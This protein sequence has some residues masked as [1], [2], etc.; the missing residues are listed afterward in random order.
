ML[1]VAK[2]AYNVILPILIVVGIG[3]WFG[4]TYRPD[5]RSLSRLAMFVLIP[6]LTFSSMADTSIDSDEMLLIALFVMGSTTT[7][8]FIGWLISRT[9]YQLSPAASSTFVLTI[10]AFNAGNFGLPFIEFAFGAN[11]LQ[12]ATLVFVSQSIMVS[13]L[14][15]YVVS[16]GSVSPVQGLKN[17]LSNPVPYATLLGIIISVTGIDLPQ[18]IN[19][20]TT[21]LGNGSIPVMLLILGMQLVNTPLRN[22]E[23]YRA[24]S[25]A[26]VTRLVL[27]PILL[28]GI[29]SLLH[30]TGITQ[31][32]LI[33]QLS[34]PT[35]V[36]TIILAGEYGGDMDLAATIILSTTL[37][38]V[39]TLSILVALLV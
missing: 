3:G 20:A 33:V 25:L 37:S 21:L 13:T 32:V 6:G 31:Q 26:T 24:V 2:I 17:V 15:I 8:A 30:I 23:L 35:A 12:R 16:S 22:R 18:N 19:R 5:I 27:V 29:T 7:F 11:G 38:S 28:Y 9:Q 39:L 34:M 4:R 10:M 36:N 1:E 14:G